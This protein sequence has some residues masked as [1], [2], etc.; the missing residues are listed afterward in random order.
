MSS[1]SVKLPVAAFV[2]YSFATTAYALLWN[3]ALGDES[4]KQIQGDVD[5]PEEYL[6]IFALI[7]LTLTMVDTLFST[8]QLVAGGE[9]RFDIL[10]QPLFGNEMLQELP[11]LFRTL[12]SAG[13]YLAT[14]LFATRPRYVAVF[15][16]TMSQPKTDAGDFYAQGRAIPY[17]LAATVTVLGA[18]L[19]QPVKSGGN[20]V[21]AFLSLTPH[22]TSNGMYSS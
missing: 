7:G 11:R 8:V 6:I 17:I 22:K 20:N 1:K 14:F 15:E 2:Y 16:H 18:V 13:V 19:S 5:S 12:G 3:Y 9:A 21:N 4:L 10:P